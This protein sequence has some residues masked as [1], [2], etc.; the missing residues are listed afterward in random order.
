[1]GQFRSWWSCRFGAMVVAVGGGAAVQQDDGMNATRSFPMADLEVLPSQLPARRGEQT[2]ELS[3]RDIRILTVLHEQRG[4][5]VARDELFDRCWG[6]SYLPSS[7][8]LDQHIS[9]LRKM[10]E[11]DPRDPKIIETVHGVGYRHDG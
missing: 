10:I 3:L 4:K 11:L 2:I 9:K 8:T 5:V 6:R 7:R 1:M